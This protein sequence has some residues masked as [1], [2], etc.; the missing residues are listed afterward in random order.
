MRPTKAQISL[1]IH[2]AS[3]VFAVCMK[4]KQTKKKKKKKKKTTTK[5]NKR[6]FD[7]PK[8]SQH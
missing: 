8:S 5:K 3:S 7:Y 1:H 4:N 6:I 2:A